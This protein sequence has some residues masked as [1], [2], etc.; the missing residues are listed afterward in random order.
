MMKHYGQ[1]ELFSVILRGSAL[2]YAYAGSMI[3]KGR[4]SF[5]KH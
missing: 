4:L 2:L 1:E 5:I 3:Q